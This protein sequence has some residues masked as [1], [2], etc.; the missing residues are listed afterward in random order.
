MHVDLYTRIW[1]VSS[2]RQYNHMTYWNIEFY[3]G[4]G[5]LLIDHLI[6]TWSTSHSFCNQSIICNL[7]RT[8]VRSWGYCSHFTSF[9]TRIYFKQISIFTKKSAVVWQIKRHASHFWLAFINGIRPLEPFKSTKQRAPFSHWHK[10][11]WPFGIACLSTGGAKPHYFMPTSPASIVYF[12]ERVSCRSDVLF[13]KTPSWLRH[14]HGSDVIDV[15]HVMGS[16]WL[17]GCGRGRRRL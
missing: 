13:F 14:W 12:A 7:C 4:N 17:P 11:N 6:Y 2:T 15:S 1:C 10:M 5:L 3:S 8:L 16:R 9:E